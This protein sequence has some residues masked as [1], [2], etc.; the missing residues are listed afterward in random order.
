MLQ[1]EVLKYDHPLPLKIPGYNVSYSDHDAVVATLYLKEIS[2]LY[3]KK[4]GTNF[5][6]V[7]YPFQCILINTF[8]FFFRNCRIMSREW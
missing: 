7:T 6:K 4:Q 1:V 5:F 2:S 8:N 3:E